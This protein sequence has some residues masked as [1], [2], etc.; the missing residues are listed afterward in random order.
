MSY[1]APKEAKELTDR[2]I[3]GT[4]PSMVHAMDASFV[5]HDGPMA[6]IMHFPNPLV[7]PTF[8]HVNRF[9]H[10]RLLGPEKGW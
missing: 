6:I 5:R 10:T 9:V 8:A 7:N 1:H 3:Q 4:W 2:K